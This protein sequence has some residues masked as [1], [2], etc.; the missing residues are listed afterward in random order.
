MLRRRLEKGFDFSAFVGSLCIFLGY[1][2]YT[3]YDL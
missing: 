2:R 3:L 1:R